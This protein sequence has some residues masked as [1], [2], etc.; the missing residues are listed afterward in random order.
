MDL[1][2]L[3]EKETIFTL[4]RLEE[5]LRF[6]Q[7]K[8]NVDTQLTYDN[9]DGVVYTDKG[10]KHPPQERLSIFVDATEFYKELSI[11]IC[12]INAVNLQLIT[13]GLISKY[14]TQ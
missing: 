9:L 6:I 4:K 3:E 8:E 7:N 12:P 10:V 14:I 5:T 1:K 11:N 13:D 2:T